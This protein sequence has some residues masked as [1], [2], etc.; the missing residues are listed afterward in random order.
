ME[1]N[2]ELP[3]EVN[4]AQEEL[5]FFNPQIEV[6][7]LPK[8]EQISYEKIQKNSFYVDL[9]V[10]VIITLIVIIGAI[11]LVLFNDTVRQYYIYLFSAILLVLS[12]MYLVDIK[13]FKHIGFALRSHD[14]I[15][16]HGWLWRSIVAIPF[17]RIQHVEVHQ[18]PIDR[19]FDLSSITLY[20]AGGSDVEI[21]GLS[22]EQAESIKAYIMSK[23]Q[24]LQK[25]HI[26]DESE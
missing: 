18:G 24:D 23:N 26:D 9:I 5:P 4:E 8:I 25:E 17:N 2:N 6:S 3:K 14:I 1:A 20:T 12:F 7:T 16:K 19:L 13:G 15:Y 11:F 10:L 21:E 22:P